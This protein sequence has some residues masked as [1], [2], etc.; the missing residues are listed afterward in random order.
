MKILPDRLRF[1]AGLLLACTIHA[2]TAPNGEE[3]ITPKELAQ[4]YGD[5]LVMAMPRTD[6][7]AT[8]DEEETRDGVRARHKFDRIRD[9]RALEVP[10]GETP[11]A[12]IA[13]L[14]ATGRYEFV[15]RDAIRHVNVTPN[16]PSFSSQYQYNN[17]GSNFGVVGA[18][19]HATAAWDTIHDAPSVIVGVI[20][21]GTRLTHS[22]LVANLWVNP[23]PNS[24]PG[25]TNATYG[26]NAVSTNGNPTDDEGHGT[27][28]AGIIGAV[29]NNGVNVTGVA[30][31]AQIMSLKFL[32][33]SG[34]GKASQEVICVDFAIKKGASILNC[35]FGDAGTNSTELS[36]LTAAR[37]AGIIVVAAA[38]N[39]SL[40]NDYSGSYPAN[41]PLDNIVSVGSSNNRD[42]ISSYS[43]YGSGSVDLFAPGE[44]I[45]SLSYSSNTGT[46]T[47]SGTSMSTPM[48]S[49]ALA[50]LKARFPSD[51]YRQ[52][53]NR[54]LRSVDRKAAFNGKA[55][56][57][58]RLNLAAAVTSTDNRPL[59]DDFADRATLVGGSIAVRSN[60]VGAS[61]ESNDP[62]VFSNGGTSLWWEWTA[63][64]S[65]TVTL[66]TSGSAYDTLLSVHTGTALG[67]LTVVASNDNNG[68][69]ATSRLTF[70]AQAGTTYEFEVEGKNSASGLTLL[71][72][73]LSPAN[74]SFATPTVISGP[75]VLIEDQNLNASRQTSEPFI[76]GSAGG[77]SLWYSW[78]APK[79]GTFQVSSYST[80][81]NPLVGVYTGSS[82]SSLTLVGS[83]RGGN[84]GGSYT[85]S[86]YAT[87]TFTATEGTAYAI[88]LDSE[89][90]TSNGVTSAS[91][92][93]FTLS[94]VD[95]AWQYASSDAFTS[96]PAVASDGTVIA[97]SND[98]SV[99]ALNPNGTLRWSY[100]TGGE[101][102]TSGAA[103]ADDG[104][105]VLG[106]N[107]GLVYAFTSTGTLKWTYTT[108]SGYYIASAPVIASDGT[109]YLKGS[110]DKFYAI[111]STGTLKWTAAVPGASYAP[112]TIGSDGTIY[113]G[114]DNN[115]LYALTPAG[116]TKWTF[117]AADQIYT[118]PAI[119]SSGNLYFATLGGQVYKLNSA[120]QQQWLYTAANG[121]S[122]SPAL[123]N[124]GVLYFGCYDKN[125]YAINTT[126]GSLKWTAAFADQ[127]RASS[128][129]IDSAGTIYIGTYAKLVYAV[130]PDGTIKRTYATSDQIR[131]SPVI[132]GNR[133]YIG[134][135]DHRVYAFDL[136]TTSASAPWPM[137]RFNAR[138]TGRAPT[139]DFQ[140]TT[141]PLA[142][143]LG[144]GSP[145]VLNVGTSGTTGLSY[146]WYKDGISIAGA[147]SATYSV[148]SI[149]ASDAGSY[150]VAITSAATSLQSDVAKVT[151]SAA[152]PG[153]LINLSVRTGAGT[154]DR[155]L[156][157]G[158]AVDH[159]TAKPILIRAIGPT[160][161]AY[162]VSGYITNPQLALYDNNS[163]VLLQGNDDWG[164]GDTLRSAFAN[165]GAFALDNNSRDAALLRALP[166]GLYSAQ[167]SGVGGTTGI[168]LA[169]LYDADSASTAQ[170][171][172]VNI[173]ARTQVGTGD[174]VLITGFGISGNIAKRLLIR[175]AGPSLGKY[176]ITGFLANPRL[177]LYRGS[178]LLQSNDDWAGTTAL[179][180]AF[181]SVAAFPFASTD[182]LDS[183]MVVTLPPGTYSAKV[184][185]VNNTTGVAL[186]EI[187]ELP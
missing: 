117:T 110:D 172:L 85:K 79:S 44:N 95:A 43:D 127:M 71:N 178:A 112:P 86:A 186:V 180:T 20:D 159:G 6:R 15:E 105:V 101:L 177:D 74:D 45:L 88:A 152:N 92:G 31:R 116:A 28:V 122:S 25:Y 147:T 163:P 182:S 77:H 21:T 2:A 115:L 126:D 3:R 185:G 41:Y 154:G 58:G 158:F 155:T 49:G 55:Q 18:D 124:G 94:L 11:D 157:V 9:L 65:G 35:S 100:P 40:N 187:Y 114:A 36:M 56:S 99:Y 93:A 135:N 76:A 161:A 160:L 10:A 125:L 80:A 156:I 39:D 81:F 67:A 183:A 141:Q 48:V 75:S 14:Q 146:Q 38:G 134:S 162:S 57:G 8:I 29:G 153:H 7:R 144:I 68:S 104:T 54:L 33:A 119:D 103:I 37:N 133:L 53:I 169:E 98:N 90:S 73:N 136:A 26:I 106:S 132:A 69:L 128:P 109:I 24:Y 50:L 4:G 42:E 120:G 175:A 16:D 72:L 97:A 19:I 139:V 164:G 150:S 168:A 107:D 121:I 102:D 12:F 176:G 64:V 63:P 66:D 113:I 22:D 78:T 60:N 89:S 148:A 87:V 23:A 30:W 174:D 143:D 96:A 1:V 34:H 5:T 137:Q 138:R 145:L 62:T 170:A 82:L 13:R 181:T 46:T 27:H 129:A 165:T 83:A 91:S 108:T 123:G 167:I 51:S 70:T 84:I 184:S 166:S 61:R 130:N 118:A 149:T 179:T 173:S 142:Q 47:K 171:R 131:S 32:D 17:T 140:L 52:L 151:V 111:S 59:N